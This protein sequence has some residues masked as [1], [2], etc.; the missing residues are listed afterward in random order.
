MR[1]GI[2]LAGIVLI[3]ITLAPAFGS[4]AIQIGIITDVHSHNVDSPPFGAENKRMTNFAERLGVFAS[5]MTAWEADAVIELGDLVNGT[6]VFGA[7]ASDDESIP[8][9]LEEAVLALTGFEGPIHYVLGNHD[10]YSLSKDEFLAAVDREETYYS[11]D[12]GGVHFVIL[13]AE[14]RS[15]GEA[16][17]HVYFLVEGYIPPEELEWLQAD[18]AA[19]TLPTIVCVHQ[20]LDSDFETLAGGPPVAN[21]LAV[22]QVL[23]DSE[24][25]VAV[26]QGHDHANVYNQIEGIHYVTFAAMVD[27]LDPT[28][29]TWAQVTLDAGQ[30]TI[31]IEGFGLQD[32][33]ELT[34]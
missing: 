25:V 10:L 28:P 23:E 17:D 7:A 15:T 27:H 8:G 21:H 30:R 22:R 34:Y 11:F 14:F 4:D 32:S 19:T 20:P 3:A 2:A 16:Y 18:L 9:I 31:A 24:Q 33:L 6:F 29:P 5:A 12:L 13:D 26:F 1:R